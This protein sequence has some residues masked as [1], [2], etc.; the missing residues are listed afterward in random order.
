MLQLGDGSSSS[1]NGRNAAVRLRA[2]KP[3]N[4]NPGKR[5]CPR[6]DSSGTPLDPRRSREAIELMAIND[7]VRVARNSA[8]PCVGATPLRAGP[9]E[10]RRAEQQ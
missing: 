4:I 1:S 6:I 2:F 5:Q 8:A 10:T 3:G 9:H 7:L